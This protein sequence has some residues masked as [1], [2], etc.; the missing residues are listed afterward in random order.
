MAQLRPV[1]VQST[2]NIVFGGSGTNLFLQVYDATGKMVMTER[3]QNTSTISL[4]TTGLAK[5]TYWI[6]LSDGITQQKGQF[7]KQ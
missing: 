3:R 1:P 2:L 5:G 6:V 4:Q 7:I